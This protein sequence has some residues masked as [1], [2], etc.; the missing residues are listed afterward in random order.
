MPPST[1][2]LDRL[3]VVAYEVRESLEAEGY[4]VSVAVDQHQS[5]TADAVAS[6]ALSRAMVKEA[7]RRG[8]GKAGMHVTPTAG[9]GLDLDSYDGN[10]HRS[11]RVK[12]ANVR[13]DGTYDVV[14]GLGSSLLHPETTEADG[15]FFTEERWLLAYTMTDDH[16]IDELFVAH[17]VGHEGDGPVHL[18]LG[19]PIHLDPTT[20]PLGFSTDD[21]DDLPGFEDDQAN[22]GDA[23]A[24]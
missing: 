18:R 3:H 19:T 6:S 9:G 14:C 7:A 24:V 23:D 16:T 1:S 20:S 5:F 11:Y 21:S 4:L 22:P 13:A 2:E 8:A 17:V 15:T 12:R 10:I